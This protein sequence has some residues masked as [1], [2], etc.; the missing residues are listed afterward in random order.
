MSEPE[1]AV[2]PFPIPLA[3]EGERGQAQTASLDDPFLRALER[4]GEARAAAEDAGIDIRR[5][6]CGGGRIPVLRR[7]GSGCCARMRS[8]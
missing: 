6:T 3:A 2:P 4:T 5:L 7:T 1:E 8:G